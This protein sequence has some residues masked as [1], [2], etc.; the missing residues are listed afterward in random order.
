MAFTPFTKEEQPTMANF[1]EKFLDAIQEAKTQALAKSAKIAT[2]SYTGTGGAEANNGVSL[3][4]EF[5]PKLLVVFY[6][7]SGG[8]VVGIVTPVV[9]ITFDQKTVE[10]S[11]TS[12]LYF[13]SSLTGNTISYYSTTNARWGLNSA[14]YT[15]EYIAIG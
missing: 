1:N 9:G 13:T 12:A 4:F 15:Y 3:T 2:G 14:G 11:V 5:V 7:W 6:R 10:N 8:C